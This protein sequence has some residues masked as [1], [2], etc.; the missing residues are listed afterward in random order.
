MPEVGADPRPRQSG[1]A[2]D[3][4]SQKQ[5]QNTS[6]PSGQEEVAERDDSA[7]EQKA[8]RG[9]PSANAPHGPWLTET[10]VAQ[11]DEGAGGAEGA[12]GMLKK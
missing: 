2:A 6:D 3:D 1:A 4:K 10:S 12:G 8:V 5:V 11:S 7:F 9:L